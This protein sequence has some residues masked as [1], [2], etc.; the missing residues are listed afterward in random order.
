DLAPL[1]TNDE[2]ARQAGFEKRVVHGAV[3]FSMISR[4]VGMHF[5]GPQSLWLKS[6]IKFHRPCYPPGAITISRKIA[7]VSTATSSV[8]L[9][10]SVTDSAGQ[11]LASARSYHK[12]LD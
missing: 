10:I 9:D 1:H 5:P 6:E 12:I 11:E 4:F 3:L 7:L 8:A 2:F